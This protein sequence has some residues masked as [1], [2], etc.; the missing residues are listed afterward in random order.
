MIII[1][2]SRK[3]YKAY[4][5][6]PAEKYS[7]PIPRRTRARMVSLVKKS[8]Y[9]ESNLL[10]LSNKTIIRWCIPLS[11]SKKIS[12][13]RSISQPEINRDEIQITEISE[14]IVEENDDFS[15]YDQIPVW[16]ITMTCLSKK[17]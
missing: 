15:N 11:Q 16:T 7:T 1:M 10:I 14:K 12:L 8:N 9:A 2:S 3:S 4:F 17:K 5:L 13:L 6:T